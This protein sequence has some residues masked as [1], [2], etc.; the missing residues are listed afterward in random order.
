MRRR[1]LK[2][3]PVQSRALDR[4]ADKIREINLVQ[5]GLRARYKAVCA[6]TKGSDIPELAVSFARDINKADR[7]WQVAE[8]TRDQDVAHR[9]DVGRHSIGARHQLVPACGAAVGRRGSGVGIR[10]DPDRIE[11][12]E[13]RRPDLDHRLAEQT[14]SHGTVRV[15]AQTGGDD[16]H[17]VLDG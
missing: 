3:T 13:V 6:V 4:A 14:V 9:P 12:V 5:E 15:G 8:K 1:T 11:D 2:F 17:P 10:V 16:T 7:R